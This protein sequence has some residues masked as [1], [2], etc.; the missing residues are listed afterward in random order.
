MGKCVAYHLLVTSFCF[1][2][3][4]RGFGSVDFDIVSRYQLLSFFPMLVMLA[5]SKSVFMSKQQSQTGISSHYIITED[6][7]YTNILTFYRT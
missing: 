3:L 5:Y 1:L 6:R 4:S 2:K 7:Y